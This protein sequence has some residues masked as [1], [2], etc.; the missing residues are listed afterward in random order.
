MNNTFPRLLRVELRKAINNKIFFTT[1]I[2]ASLFALLSAWY[3]IDSYF[4]FQ[5]QNRILGTSGNPMTEG[6]SLYNHWI[7]GEGTSLGSTLFFTLL[8]L[9]AALP[10]GWSYFIENKTGYAKSVMIRSN[11]WQYFLAKYLATFTAGGL[12]VLSPLVI[13]F[14]VVASFIPATTPSMLYPLYYAVGHGS[15]WSQLF[16]TH[17]VIFVILY[18]ILDFVF[19]GLF[20][21]MSLTVSLLVKNRI[22]VLLIPFFL[23]LVLHYSRTF[24]AYKYF[25]EISPLHYLHSTS[26]ENPTNVWIILVQ[27]LLFFLLTFGIT[28]KLGGKREIL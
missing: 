11:K 16:Y 18:L 23:I 19:A 6:F 15:L 25:Y 3:M 28:M 26:L 10:Y 22:A 7:G 9:L 27:G 5:R 20:A 21:T 4:Y 8:P 24:L 13:N 17:P 14:L 1:L 2:I 12:V